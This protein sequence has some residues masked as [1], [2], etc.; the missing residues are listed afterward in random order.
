MKMRLTESQRAYLISQPVP[1]GRHNRI[2][3]A[4]KEVDS[5]QSKLA[6]VLGITNQQISSYIQGGDL[7]LSTAGRIAA[8]FGLTVTDL[9]PTPPAAKAD[10]RRKA[11]KTT[12]RAGKRV[13]PKSKA[14]GPKA[15][16]AMAS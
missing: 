16:L 11:T 3:M 4:L 10:R 14:K 9:W 1:E 12:A 7:M 8:V 6:A 13:N 15:E 2:R 5:N